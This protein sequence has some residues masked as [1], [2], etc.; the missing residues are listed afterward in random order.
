M[1]CSK[2]ILVLLLIAVL[3]TAAAG[4]GTAKVSAYDLYTSSVQKL[5]QLKDIDLSMDLTMQISIPGLSFSIPVKMDLKVSQ[6][7]EKP[8]AAYEVSASF[9]DKNINFSA[10]MKDSVFYLSMKENKIKWNIPETHSNS[11]NI[12]EKIQKALLELDESKITLE[13]GK[14]QAGGTV[15]A[16]TLPGEL[17]QEGYALVFD[18]I[19]KEIQKA[20]EKQKEA[21]DA[22][23]AES[24]ESF[25]MDWLS[26]I[27]YSD[28]RLQ[29]TVEKD[30]NISAYDMESQLSFQLPEEFLYGEAKNQP[31]T[32]TLNVTLKGTIH[33]PGKDV[34]ISEPEDLNRYVEKDITEIHDVL[35][36]KW[37][38][39]DSF[40]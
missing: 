21:L 16:V 4:C 36:S 34:V 19:Q 30:G 32:V 12:D 10:Y 40:I 35:G 2:V 8:V 24:L 29:F 13:R 1:K 20:L 5:S 39:E 27:Q 38:T 23:D 28:V 37:S 15:I 26:D 14:N 25:S 11:G 3:I 7:E 6:Q 31:Q 22:T 17:I 9:M 18:P 33:N